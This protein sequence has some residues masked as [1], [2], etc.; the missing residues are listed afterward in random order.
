M[1]DLKTAVLKA[2]DELPDDLLQKL[3]DSMPSW[4]FEVIRLHGGAT[5]Y[6]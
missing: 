3:I 6:S 1:A 4:I 2:W 5:H